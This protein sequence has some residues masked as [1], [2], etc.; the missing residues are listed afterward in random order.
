MIHDRYGASQLSYL[1][2]ALR[3]G[4]SM[5]QALHSVLR[6]SYE[7]IDREIAAYLAGRYGN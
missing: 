7:E 5:S 6:M 4:E 2:Q 3:R 1:L